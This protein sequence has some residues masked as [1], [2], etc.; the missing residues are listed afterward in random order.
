INVDSVV[1]CEVV[2]GPGT[3]LQ[4]IRRQAGEQARAAPVLT[5]MLISQITKREQSARA[6]P[7]QGLVVVLV[8]V[9]D[10]GVRRR[11]GD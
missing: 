10:L 11:T 3:P 6:T 1:G 9:D 7:G 2:P 5:P 8:K 4:P